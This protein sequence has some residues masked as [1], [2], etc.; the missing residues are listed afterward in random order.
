MSRKL[1]SAPASQKYQALIGAPSGPETRLTRPV[2]WP[3]LPARRMA[4]AGAMVTKMPANSLPT[5]RIGAQ[6]NS[7]PARTGFGVIARE[8]SARP[9]SSPSRTRLCSAT[10]VPMTSKRT[11]GFHSPDSST[12]PTTPASS[13]RF[14]LPCSL[15]GESGVGSSAS[16]SSSRA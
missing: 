8:S 7:L 11:P 4:M 3:S 14:H 15:S 5:S 9:I 13:S 1:D 12:A 2:S 6:S 10:G 16:S